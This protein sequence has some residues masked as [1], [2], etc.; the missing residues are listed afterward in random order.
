M[1]TSKYLG[2]PQTVRSFLLP[3]FPSDSLRACKLVSISK[4]TEVSHLKRNNQ[5]YLFLNLSKDT[6]FSSVGTILRS[7]K[8]LCHLRERTECTSVYTKLSLL[9]L[10]CRDSIRNLFGFK[11]NPTSVHF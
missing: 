4:H 2:E 1:N 6:V 10:M 5:N 7:D 8:R 11:K 3:G 9:L